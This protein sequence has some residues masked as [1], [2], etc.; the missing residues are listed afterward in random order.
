MRLARIPALARLPS[1]AALCALVLGLPSTFKLAADEKPDPA[2]LELFEKRIRP[3]LIE[4]CYRCH[5]PEAKEVQGELLLHT[6]QATR[7]GGVSG[8]GVVPG[9]V[10]ESLVIKAIRYGTDFYQMPPE[11]KLPADLIADFERWV[12]LGAPDP[13]D[14]AA[15][16]VAKSKR[17][18]DWNEARR[19]WA[20]QPP[21]RATPPDVRDS[22]WSRDALDPLLLAPLEAARL[23][24][25]PA[26]ERHVWLRRATYDLRGV[27]PT[28][29][30]LDEFLDDAGP[31]AASRVVDRLLASPRYGERWGRHWLDVARYSDS[32]G[33]DENLAYA[34]AY[35]YR[36]WV[37][38]SL[39]ADLPY[40]RFLHEQLAGDLLPPTDG[41]TDAER[42]SRLIATTFLSLGPKMLACDDGRKM[43]L[44]IV[45]EQVD[46]FSRV[47]LGLTMGCARC[48]DHKYD[49]LLMRDYYGLAGI[50]KSTKTMENFGVVAVWHE[51]EVASPA[52][53]ERLAAHEARVKELQKS[54]DDRTLA[55]QREFLD[56]Q[57]AKAGDYLATAADFVNF[58]TGGTADGR[59]SL[60][61]TATPQSLAGRG[62]LFEAEKYTRGNLQVDTTN[63]G[64]DCGVLLQ[65]GFAEYDIELPVDGQYQIE[66]RYAAK[67]ARPVKLSLDGQLLRADAARATTGGWFVANQRWHVEGLYDAKAGK[68]V[69]RIERDGAVPHIDKVLIVCESPPTDRKTLAPRLALDQPAPPAGSIVVEAENYRRGT[70]GKAGPFIQNRGDGSFLNSAEYAFDIPADGNYQL[71]LLYASGASRSVELYVNEQLV[72]AKAVTGVT[73]SFGIDTAK[74]LAEHVLPL[75]RGPNTMRLEQRGATPHIDKLAL[76]P[77]ELAPT[78]HLRP[79]RRSLGEL[80]AAAKARGLNEELLNQWIAYLGAKANDELWAPWRDADDERRA[81]LI[82]EWRGR[83]AAALDAVA[84][85]ADDPRKKPSGE[86]VDAALEAARSLLFA[87]DG[88]FKTPRQPEKYY[89]D[90]SKSELKKQ[91][92]EIAK[93][94]SQ[95][96]ALPRAM[97]V[98]EGKVE[99]LR[100]HIRGNYLTL[101]EPA[102]RAFP[103]VFFD[104]PPAPLEASSS[105]RLP[106]AQ[107]LTR[108]DHPLTAR[109]MANRVWLWHF[110]QGLVRSP[111]NFGE[112][113]ERPTNLPLL[114]ELATDLVAGGWS[115]KR[116]H[117][118]LMLSAA[119]GMSGRANDAAL[120]SD[121]ENRLWW[122]F[123]R[124]RLE[125]EEIRDSVLA[126]ADGVDWQIGGQMMTS[127]NR[128]Y[129]TKLNNYTVPRRSVYLPVL[130]SAVYD[131]FTAFDFGDPS[132]VQGQRSSTT[133]A[134]QA[135]FMM[136]DVLVLSQSRRLAQ[137]ELAK[138][139]HNDAQRVT[140]IY[141]RL[142]SRTPTD[143]EMSRALAFVPKYQATLADDNVPADQRIERAWQAL[144]HVLLAANE[145]VYVD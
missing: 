124:R 97:G 68:H 37:I 45:D 131:L 4:H 11:K 139:D 82:D 95:T 13:R 56:P 62:L 89:S 140:D 25:A 104:Q 122:R 106:L 20:F 135:L 116:L 84:A 127:K 113:G 9:K 41:E 8:P 23:A 130:R 10:D 79:T 54:L 105:G 1:L 128:D 115:L 50:F 77:T 66:L 34:N 102:P 137:L 60:G 120:A 46:T 61:E 2:G 114:D 52:D 123:P 15:P 30:Q 136:N 83:F 76:T 141:R 42:H 36:D 3:A 117:R 119:Y 121:P 110:G 47:V 65:S 33:L 16:Q 24:P 144:V 86:L 98:K 101:G 12:K 6:M 91:Q 18:I 14:G 111:D 49:P 87:A 96:P 143:P 63:W 58:R 21:S 40:D 7:K 100:V 99:D 38:A 51:H 118:R 133:V 134:P 125:A 71:D 78:V 31:D 57:R 27:P 43:E 53:R 108:P 126:V 70:F 80:P 55:A 88:P 59:T 109:V 39:N 74:W 22:K 93:A 69:L 67:E 72:D 26:A 64:K 44:D 73:G 145:L 112:L 94:K 35:R 103:R 28:T 142:Y 75:K 90:A 85:P 29:E 138:S 5:S 48:H 32:N 19:F 17:E 132:V 107:W 129:V 81:K 92:D